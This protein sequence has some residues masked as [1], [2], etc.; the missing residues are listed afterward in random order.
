V[1]QQ[2][3]PTPLCSTSLPRSNRPE[4][5]DQPIEDLAALAE[6][7]RDLRFTDP[8]LGATRLLWQTL[9]PF[10][11]QHHGRKQ[12]LLDVACGA[13]EAP[14]SIARRARQHGLQLEAIASDLLMPALHLVRWPLPLLCH[15]LQRMPFTDHSIDYVSCMLALHH[16]E[17]AH[18]RQ[19]LAEMQRVARHAVIVIDLQR[20]WLAYLGARLLALGPWGRMARHDGPLSVLRAFTPQ[21]LSQISA[22]LPFRISSHPPLLLRAVAHGPA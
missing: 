18:A 6:N 20:S 3:Q 1:R 2:P 16:F 12:M 4:L 9:L 13:A 15:D 22:E 21:E 14:A 10:L 5:L 17:P 19:A 11:R 7:L 8:L